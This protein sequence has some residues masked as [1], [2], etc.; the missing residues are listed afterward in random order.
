MIYI[1]TRVRQPFVK[2]AKLAD[3]HHRQHAGILQR[4]KMFL[5]FCLLT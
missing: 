4:D 5:L 1:S 3:W 2:L